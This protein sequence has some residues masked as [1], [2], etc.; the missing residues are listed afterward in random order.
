MESPMESP[1]LPTLLFTRATSKVY[2]PAFLCHTANLLLLLY[3]ELRERKLTRDISGNGVL[4]IEF[5][6]FMWLL[7]K[8]L[9]QSH[10]QATLSLSAS[11]FSG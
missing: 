11:F 1:M 8:G 3:L 2:L 5:Q 7:Y 10:L 4:L 6:L 9:R